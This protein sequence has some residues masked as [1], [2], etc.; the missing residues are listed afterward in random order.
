MASKNGWLSLVD[1]KFPHY[2]IRKGKYGY[3]LPTPAMKRMGFQNIPCG[4]DGVEAWKIAK[5]WEE[6]YQRARKGLELAP[7][8][9]NPP[10]SVAD[11][12]ARYRLLNEWK[13]KKPRT[14][15]DWERGWKYINP[16]FGASA[17]SLITVEQIDA[18][19]HRILT[20]K[21]AG[22]AGRAMK[23][24][25]SLYRVLASMKLCI[26]DHDPSQ[27]IRK[28]GVA[29][30]TETWREGE[31]VRLVKGSIR[32]GYGGL[33]CIIA[34]AW[35][36]QFSPVDARTLSPAN[37][38]TSGGDMAFS[39]DRTKTSEAALG[40][41]S[42]R[43]QRLVEWYLAALPFALHEDA[44]LFWTRGFM[45]IGPKVRAD[46]LVVPRPTPKIA[47]W[48]TLPTFVVWS[49]DLMKRGS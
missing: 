43:S 8:N 25:R 22:E 33:A 4:R 14:R 26:P 29:G 47:L 5:E 11:G 19:Y 30:R 42:R 36:T 27:A 44:P 39:I 16:V 2:V 41:L 10:G 49:L 37:A 46:V 34:V 6:R 38:V 15:E 45:S 17:P 9:S 13:K 7:A 23:T 32:A 31:V 35:D 12:F 28:E 3:W 24:W 1:I 21:G 48:M 40:I 18:W 20:L